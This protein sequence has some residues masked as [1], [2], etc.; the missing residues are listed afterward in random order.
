ME[1][2]GLGSG[3][4]ASCVSRF[5]LN[6]C[7]PVCLEPWLALCSGSLSPEGLRTDILQF[8]KHLFLVVVMALLGSERF[9]LCFS[10]IYQSCCK[11]LPPLNFP[12]PIT[13]QKQT[14]GL[15]EKLFKTP[16][17]VEDSDI[18]SALCVC[19]SNVV[20]CIFG[21]QGLLLYHTPLAQRKEKPLVFGIFSFQPPLGHLRIPNFFHHNLPL[22]HIKGTWATAFIRRGVS[23][24]TVVCRRCREGPAMCLMSI[25]FALYHSG[26]FKRSRFVQQN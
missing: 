7:D 1:E 22:R 18:V 15:C 17:I 20:F 8:T 12:R 13:T 3:Y 5:S 25:D 24:A 11:L 26:S 16:S 6:L 2:L 10:L 19:V 14:H 21:Y 23:S 4:E 9:C